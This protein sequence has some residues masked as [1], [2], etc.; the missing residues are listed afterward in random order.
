M[1]FV[2]CW[3]AISR[4]GTP[5]RL[6][7]GVSL[8]SL[9]VLLIVSCS[10]SNVAQEEDGE[11]VVASI[12]SEFIPAEGTVT[13][14]GLTL[15]LSN[16]SR[17][18]GWSDSIALSSAQSRT[19]RNAL[20]SL[21]TP[22]CDDHKLLSC[23]C[24]RDGQSCNLVRSAKG[25]TAHLIQNWDYGIDELKDAL[26]QWLK[27]ARPDY[28]IAQELADRRMDPEDFNLPTEGSCYRN[29]CTTPIAE[30]GC[31]GMVRL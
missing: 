9:L 30:G 13:D 15:S 28:Y 1:V 19:Y 5:I 23:C 8:V 29:L 16:V 4:L 2:S 17:F 14:Y 3:H 24:E 22:C 7:G 31:G 25:L 18:A 20:N 21:P 6:I 10:S 27:F 26:L 12:R 11:D